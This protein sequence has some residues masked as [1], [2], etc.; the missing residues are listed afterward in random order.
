MNKNVWRVIGLSGIVL[1][2]FAMI[3]ANYIKN[4]LMQSDEILESIEQ[5]NAISDEL[6]M[7]AK[8]VFGVIEQAR[9][10][11][12]ELTVEEQM[13]VN[14]FDAKYEAKQESLTTSESLL[15]SNLLL[16][17]HETIPSSKLK[18]EAN[19]YEGYR[20]EVLKYL[21]R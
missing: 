12:R 19:R 10:E 21:N 20:E 6:K 17:S 15:V 3:G 13:L 2:I 11:Q 8:Q 4:T 9:Q 1:I 16:M 18:S 5:Q 14:E 7:D